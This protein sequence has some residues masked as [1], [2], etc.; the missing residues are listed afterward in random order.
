MHI[1]KRGDIWIGVVEIG[2]KFLTENVT[3][4][5]M[6]RRNEIILETKCYSVF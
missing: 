3:L 1:D 2:R 5:V 6:A 4:E